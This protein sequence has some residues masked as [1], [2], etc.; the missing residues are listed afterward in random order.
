VAVPTITSVT[1]STGSSQGG[2]LVTIVGTNF[3]TPAVGTGIPTPNVYPSVRVT[4]GGVL[5]EVVL[6]ASAS[7]VVVRTPDYEGSVRAAAGPSGGPTPYSQFPAVNVVLQNLNASGIPVTGETVTR[8]G[9]YQFLRRDLGPPRARGVYKRAQDALLEWLRRN[10]CKTVSLGRHSE[11]ADGVEDEVRLATLPGIGVTIRAED[12][13]GWAQFTGGVEEIPDPT[14]ATRV[15]V[16]DG[17][18]AR[19]LRVTLLLGGQGIDQCQEL[20]EALEDAVERQGYLV[21]PA[22]PDVVGSGSTAVDRY[23]WFWVETPHVASRGADMDVGSG[24][25]VLLV[26]GLL[27]MSDEPR[28]RDWTI[29]TI[30]VAEAD[31]D[32]DPLR[33][34]LV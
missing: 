34:A 14:D 32:G 2:T 6:V 33:T 21:L 18:R 23:P 24:R 19:Q 30:E 11:Y 15:L 28:E 13:P 12:D 26:R 5:A 17:M 4:F 9:G 22:D 25:A 31:M 20:C 7:E 3:P 10:V 29:T 16:Y 8:V 1:P 27:I